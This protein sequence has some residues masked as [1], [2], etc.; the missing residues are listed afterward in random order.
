MPPVPFGQE[1]AG[2]GVAVVRQGTAHRPRLAV[3]DPDDVEEHDRSVLTR[4]PR[5]FRPG[6]AV[7]PQDQRSVQV[8]AFPDHP[9]VRC[10][11]RVRGGEPGPPGHGGLLD[12]PPALRGRPVQQ[13]GPFAP[14]R[15]PGR[16][17]HPHL[18]RGRHGDVDQLRPPGVTRRRNGLGGPPNAVE[19]PHQPAAHRPDLVGCRAGDRGW[20]GEPGQAQR[21]PHAVPFVQ[22]DRPLV[23]D[24]D[25]DRPPVTDTRHPGE[26]DRTVHPG[27][28]RDPVP[29]TGRRGRVRGDREQR[30]HEQHPEGYHRQWASSF[31]LPT[32][33]PGVGWMRRSGSTATEAGLTTPRS[34]QRHRL[35][36]E[37]SSTGE[38]HP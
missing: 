10:V 28:G 25:R 13:Q 23:V 8:G 3:A 6:A 37:R 9:H 29:E 12:V 5:V 21:G 36:H 16:P 19:P 14:T 31:H 32:P 38:N 15:R 30:G 20:F 4:R 7:P 22:R 24:P 35:G 34:W 33:C 1:R 27:L 18:T 17:H 2:F 26:R 11:P